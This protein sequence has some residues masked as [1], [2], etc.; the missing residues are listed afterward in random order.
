[1]SSWDDLRAAV[2]LADELHFGRAAQRLHVAQPS[3]TRQIRRLEARVGALLFER[4]TRRVALTEAGDAYVGAAR[5]ALARAAAA[6]ADARA[7]A[8]GER[9]RLRLA[10]PGSAV[11]RVV[12]G[13]LVRFGAT[14]PAVRLE[15]TELFDD[16]AL[17]AAVVDGLV[18][19]SFTRLPAR[20]A[21]LVVHDLGREPL[22]AVLPTGHRLAPDPGSPVAEVE[23]GELADERLLLWPRAVSPASHDELA[24]VFAAA[25]VPMRVAQEVPT[26]QTLLALV[27]A[28]LGV[29]VLAESYS[30]LRRHGVVFRRLAGPGSRLH[31]IHRLDRRSALLDRFV[32]ACLGGED[33]ALRAIGRERESRPG[34]SG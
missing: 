2:T 33:D 9:G 5:D 28:G 17:T 13:A 27:A 3:L 7:V 21:G 26:A 16:D 20:S 10:Y 6:E 32:E 25:G 29:G 31:L 30:V 18:D 22:A 4:T 34:M 15:L 12:P 24:G 14:D 23:V 1:M 8:R 19:A 11:N